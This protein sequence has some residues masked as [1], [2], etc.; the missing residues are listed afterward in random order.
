MTH[1]DGNGCVLNVELSCFYHSSRRRWFSPIQCC[2]CGSVSKILYFMR[3]RPT[4]C[5]GCSWYP[6]HIADSGW[7]LA[8]RTNRVVAADKRL[9]GE[10]PGIIWLPQCKAER[11]GGRERGRWPVSHNSPTFCRPKDA[12]ALRSTGSKF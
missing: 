3:I 4:E 12:I 1:S 10:T 2:R 6:A 5:T 8:Y 11:Q 9:D 7:V